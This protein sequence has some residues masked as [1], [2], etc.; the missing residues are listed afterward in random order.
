MTEEQVNIKTRVSS[1]GR[2]EEVWRKNCAKAAVLKPLA[3]LH[4]LASGS[5]QHNSVSAEAESLFP[6]G[7]C[8]SKVAVFSY[9]WFYWLS[10]EL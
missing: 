9:N 5:A 8:S 6:M 3:S 4:F 1:L 7:R 2:L 10:E